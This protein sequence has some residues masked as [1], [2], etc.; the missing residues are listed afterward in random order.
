MH[1]AQAG[2]NRMPAS[3]IN[4]SYNNTID[5]HNNET[6]VTEITEKRHQNDFKND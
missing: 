4:H 3:D 5:Y 1:L 6:A 2:N